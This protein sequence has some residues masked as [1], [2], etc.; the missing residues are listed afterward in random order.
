MPYD[1]LCQNCANK[2]SNDKPPWFSFHCVNTTKYNHASD[3]YICPACWSSKYIPGIDIITYTKTK[4]GKSTPK[5]RIHKPAI[6]AN[7]PA[8]IGFHVFFISHLSSTL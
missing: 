8:T 1:Y 7:I 3:Y 5:I 6:I 2:A 4:K